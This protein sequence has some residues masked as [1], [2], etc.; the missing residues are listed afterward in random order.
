MINEMILRKTRIVKL[1]SFG[2]ASFAF[3]SKLVDVL[4][5]LDSSP[6]FRHEISWVFGAFD[7]PVAQLSCLGL[8]LHQQLPNS[9]DFP[10]HLH[11]TTP[12]ATDESTNTSSS[13]FIPQS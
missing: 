6:R 4:F 5:V 7:F 3:E 2:T 8:L 1:N 9:N 13:N 10:A 11:P 12:S